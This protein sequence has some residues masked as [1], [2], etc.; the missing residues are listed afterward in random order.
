MS[1][2]HPKPV[3]VVTGSSSG[4]GAA[5]ALLFAQRGH[6]VVINYS[7]RAEPAQAVAEQCRQAGADALVVQ[8]DV[9]DNAQCLALAD[10]VRLRWGRADALVNSAGI[11]TKFVDIKDLDALTTEDFEAIYRVN[12]IGAFQMSRA[13]APL[14]KDRAPAGIVNISS[15]AGRMGA[16]SSIAYAASKGALNTLTLSLAR[17]LAPAIRVNAILPGMVD[18]DWM[19]KGLGPEVFETRRQRYA[20]RALLNEVV[21]PVDVART[22]HW[23]AV[24]ATRATGQL[25][26]MD[27]GFILG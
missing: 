14:M 20:A 25:I 11:T 18:S 9:A 7:K 1:T 3:C 5:T 4:I 16:G 26:D 22:A 23:L 21:D 10:E 24:D 13:I 15:M 2:S 27:A 8:A 12:V 17:A 6:D 19:R